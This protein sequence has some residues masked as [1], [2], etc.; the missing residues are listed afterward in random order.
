[1]V[2]EVGWRPAQEVTTG[3]LNS[4]SLNSNSNNPKINININVIIKAS[5]NYIQ[6]Y[7]RREI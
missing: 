3:E 6:E 5:C 1:M 4:K 7:L 2:S